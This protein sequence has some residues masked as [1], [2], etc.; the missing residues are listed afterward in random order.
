MPAR[1]TVNLE[2]VTAGALP[3]PQTG[4][5]VNAAV[6]GA[7]RDVDPELAATIHDTKGFKPLTI[8]PLLDD[9]DRAVGKASRQAGFEVG[10]LADALTASVLVAASG[11]PEYRIGNTRYQ[12]KDAGVTA[13]EPYAELAGSAR[14]ASAWTFDLVTPT[15][16]ASSRGTGARR[17]LPWPDPSRV[18]GNL[19]DRWAAFSP[20]VPLPEGVEDALREH[21]EIT[22]YD[23]RTAQHLVKAGAP[24]RRGAVGRVM[25][26]V[27]EAHQVG[28]DVLAALD[29][30]ARYA[31]YAGFA[32]RTAMGM[33]VVRLR[34]DRRWA[35][36]HPTP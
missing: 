25:Y 26:Q 31:T 33:G 29:A 7:I 14:P 5:A 22:E 3:P 21:L 20:E 2:P 9:N 28:G 19:A 12:V 6:M 35:L 11:V 34:Q 36:S 16:F 17:E 4:P 13:A 24:L 18:F 10:V 32:D 1:I 30:L 27:A 15:G 8:A 23:L